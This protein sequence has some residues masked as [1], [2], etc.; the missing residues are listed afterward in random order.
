MEANIR[1]LEKE[2]R[3]ISLKLSELQQTVE[4]SEDL[5][6]KLKTKLCR[7]EQRLNNKIRELEEVFY[8]SLL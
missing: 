7:K 2:K 6:G 5:N 3:E 1:N 8:W 4:K